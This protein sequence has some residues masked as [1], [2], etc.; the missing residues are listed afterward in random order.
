MKC[1]Q[2]T[3][4]GDEANAETSEESSGNKQ[5]NGGSGGL[6][7]DA[8]GEDAS[9]CDQT[10]SASEDI[11][12]RRC[13]EGTEESAGR[14]DRHNRGLLGRG[15]VGDLVL[16][17]R[18][19]GGEELSPVCHGQNTTNRTGIISRHCQSVRSFIARGLRQS[20]ENTPE[21]DT[22]KGNEQPDDD[23]RRGRACH[24][25]GFLEHYPHDDGFFSRKTR[26]RF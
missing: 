3:Q 20:S 17:V 24:M 16:G 22:P 2:H 4:G 11:T 7:D 6:E 19:T 14:K 13:A 23:G 9:G 8:K 5:W 10:P 12:H 18:V 21:E 26:A 25:L 1:F 15:D